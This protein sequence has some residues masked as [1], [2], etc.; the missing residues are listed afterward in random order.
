MK[1]ATQIFD[2]PQKMAAYLTDN[3]QLQDFFETFLSIKNPEE[4]KA[5]EVRFWAYVTQLPAIEQ[6]RIRAANAKITQRLYD[7]MGSM[8]IEIH[9][10]IIKNEI[11]KEGL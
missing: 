2:S 1:K 10:L 8:I 7:R 9:H 3:P 4:R 6:V 5:F 11:T